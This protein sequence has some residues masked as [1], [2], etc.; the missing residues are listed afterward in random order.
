MCAAG[1]SV[2]QINGPFSVSPG[3]RKKGGGYDIEQQERENARGEKER[4]NPNGH[5]TH[6]NVRANKC[7]KQVFFEKEILC[8]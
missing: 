7:V 5:K 6:S 4:G 1:A 3:E 8:Y 2:I